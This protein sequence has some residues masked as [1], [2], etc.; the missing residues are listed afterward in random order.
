MEISICNEI[1]MLPVRAVGPVMG[2]L[3]LLLMVAAALATPKAA[4]VTVAE[5]RVLVVMAT[6]GKSVL[7]LVKVAH[8]RAI[9]SG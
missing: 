2:R 7:D 6:S 9:L 5:D 1:G 8:L 3:V 4:R